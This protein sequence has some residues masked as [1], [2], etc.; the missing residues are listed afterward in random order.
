MPRGVVHDSGTPTRV[1]YYQLSWNK[2]QLPLSLQMHPP[3]KPDACQHA[4]VP[5]QNTLWIRIAIES[6]CVREGE[7][8]ER[9]VEGVRERTHLCHSLSPR[10]IKE[11]EKKKKHTVI[12]NW[13]CLL[14]Q[15]AVWV[16][17]YAAPDWKWF[18]YFSRGCEIIN[19]RCVSGE[20]HL[21]PPT[22]RRQK[23]PMR[24]LASWLRRGKE[25]TRRPPG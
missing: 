2:K 25:R 9:E 1:S 7:R 13:W 23:A 5:W 17:I 19:L 21:R 8:R 20:R 24:P 18:I 16:K 15:I 10:A 11:E 12:S 4:N 14:Q 3:S 6:V 22:L